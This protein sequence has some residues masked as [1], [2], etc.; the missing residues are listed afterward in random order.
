M[1]LSTAKPSSSFLNGVHVY[2]LGLSSTFAQPATKAL[3]AKGGRVIPPKIPSFFQKAAVVSVSKHLPPD[4][5]HLL[6]GDKYQDASPASILK[7]LGVE[8]PLPSSIKVVHHSW[9]SECLKMK[10]CVDSAPFEID[11]KAKPV[12]PADGGGGGVLGKHPARVDQQ[13][14]AST[15]GKRPRSAVS[16]NLFADDS[17]PPAPP[18]LQG[19]TPKRLSYPFIPPDQEWLVYD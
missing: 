14:G 19:H 1:T 16:S 6:C 3:Q 12:A 11:M 15:N 7:D 10:K 17:L 13:Q 9:L 8:G 18:L 2:F 5:T 4:M